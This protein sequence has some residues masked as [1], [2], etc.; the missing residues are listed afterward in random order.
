VFEISFT[1]VECVKSHA[2]VT[3]FDI[4]RKA[5]IVLYFFKQNGE[6]VEKH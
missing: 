5:N 2:H 6:N 1:P 3:Y 4:Q